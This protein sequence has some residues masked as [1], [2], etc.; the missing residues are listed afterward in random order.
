MKILVCS[1]NPVKIKAAEEAFSSYFKRFEII[2]LDLNQFSGV[3]RQPLTAKETLE[4]AVKRIEIAQIK[5]KADYYISLEG[6]L[7][8]DNYGTFLTWFVCI[9]DDQKVKSIAGGGRMPLPG[10]IYKELAEN[11]EKELGDVID[12][13][14]GKS[15]TK[16]HGGA[17]ALFTDG[18]IMRKEV[19][20]RDIII[21]LV[22]FTSKIYQKMEK[23]EE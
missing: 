16:R 3:Y 23:E 22:P 19:F 10:N 11:E 9:S 21:A 17:T 6:G 12:K 2:S 7:G 5:E 4:S 1:K 14:S 18:R 13:I 8:K 15:D 20:K